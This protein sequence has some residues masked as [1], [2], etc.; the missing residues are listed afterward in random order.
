MRKILLLLLGTLLLSMQLL[1]QERTITGKVTDAN[2]NPVPGASV[3]VQNTRTGT[4]T[5]EDGSF[6]ISVPANRRTLIV[7]AIGQAAQ[8]ITIGSQTNISVSLQAASN[9]S[10]QE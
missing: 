4:V 1:A 9:N 8:E 3:Q 6:S 10:M 2:G 5:K 7:S